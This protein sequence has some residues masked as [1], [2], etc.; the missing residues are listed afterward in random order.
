MRPGDRLAEVQ[1]ARQF[2]V[3]R[4]PVRQAIFRLEAERFAER[5][6]QRGLIVRRIPAHEVEEVYTVRAMLDGLAA[7]LAA[8][9]ARPAD[10][11]RLRWLNDR[12]AEAAVRTDYPA[13]AELN[14]QFHEALCEAAQNSMLLHFV[15]QL[16]DWV[17]R[18]GATTFAVPGRAQLALAEHL[19]IIEAIEAGS[20]DDAEHRARAHMASA[21]QA[22]GV[23]LA[24]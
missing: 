1:L 8:T 12:L 7:R 9:A 22:R 16:H 15:R 6:E 14:I 10:H 18:F 23:L 4:T 5:H 24:R 3:S 11:A 19:L 20:P 2:D 13:L 21:H 17:R